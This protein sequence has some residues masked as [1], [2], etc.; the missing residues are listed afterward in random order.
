LPGA[1]PGSSGS[2]FEQ[3]WEKY[4]WLTADIRSHRAQHEARRAGIKSAASSAESDQTEAGRAA[5][6]NHRAK[7]S[8]TRPAYGNL[9][10]L[11]R[12]SSLGGLFFPRPGSAAG[13][14]AI[15]QGRERGRVAFK[16]VMKQVL[17]DWA[18]QI[19]LDD[20]EVEEL[21][22]S[23]IE[24]K[25]SANKNPSA[26]PTN[27][28]K[29]RSPSKPQRRRR[30]GSLQASDGDVEEEQIPPI[31]TAMKNFRKAHLNPSPDRSPSP[32]PPL[33]APDQQTIPAT[34]RMSV[35]TTTRTTAAASAFVTAKPS[36][37]KNTAVPADGSRRGVR[38]TVSSDGDVLSTIKPE[39]EHLLSK[40]M[41][42]GTI[43]QMRLTQT[44]RPAT[45]PNP[46]L[47]YDAF[48]QTH[49][50]MRRSMAR[51]REHVYKVR[52]NLMATK[53]KDVAASILRKETRREELK[54]E[55]ERA[56]RQVQFLQ[57]VSMNDKI[58]IWSDA[59][60]TGRIVRKRE[61]QRNEAASIIQ[62]NWLNHFSM[63]MMKLVLA[64]KNL[65]LEFSLKVRIRRKHRS[66]EVIKTFM[67]KIKKEA[68]PQIVKTF[69]YNVRKAQTYVRTFLA[70]RKARRELCNRYWV[71]IEHSIRGEMSS[72]AR[73]HREVSQRLLAEIPDMM[74]TQFKYRALKSKIK[75][76]L[77]K[78]KMVE[79]EH[80]LSKQVLSSNASHH[81]HA[82][83]STT[84]KAKKEAA[85]AVE[86]E[87]EREALKKREEAH[88][89]HFID[90]ETREKLVNKFVRSMRVAYIHETSGFK[91]RSQNN[92]ITDP[93]AAK[94]L[95]KGGKAE[96]Q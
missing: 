23:L 2:T 47:D 67:D 19:G 70:C 38:I 61:Q 12:S 28:N 59:L 91:E 10:N 1:S 20:K 63:R 86:K 8:V 29:K 55:R 17:P 30:G 52:S 54:A 76:Q 9:E 69:M 33:L 64:F 25:W 83:S 43:E 85:L 79:G 36:S 88:K 21:T 93:N 66:I 39:Y 84:N 6:S 27:P 41:Q 4:S 50:E 14:L 65:G 56:M 89:S 58:R 80:K 75:R 34:R 15:M 60:V 11:K 7:L 49:T 32:P 44:T 92:V 82:H 94:I 57:L 62:R 37:V 42:F 77:M 45:T 46:C 78:T 5:R 90:T 68:G 81:H 96:M 24:R 51:H 13:K 53:E 16:A 95:F 18:T 72:A 22:L 35:T 26:L 31:V 40:P 74:E 87:R 48:T 71:K 73:L 3:T